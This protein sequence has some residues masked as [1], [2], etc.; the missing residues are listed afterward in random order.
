MMA[1]LF[2]IDFGARS[3]GQLC[4]AETRRDRLCLG[5]QLIFNRF[6]YLMEFTPAQFLEKMRKYC[7]YQERSHQQVRDRLY[8]AGLYQ[9]NVEEIISVLIVE[10]YL[11]EE[12]FARSY[13]RGKFRINGWGRVKI[14][15]GLKQ[16][17]VH[18]NGIK[19]AMTEIPDEDYF[20]ALRN[21]L[22]Q[23]ARNLKEKHPV[24]RKGALVRFAAQRGFETE[25]I[26]DLL[27]ES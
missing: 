2:F 1:R 6:L 22:E 15:Q 4:R 27:G 24:R 16:H 20:S 5:A 17:R 18:A 9:D 13:A 23:K 8:E 25:L 19:A 26:L 12:R 3:Y 14:V 7:S 10:N 21:I 11:N